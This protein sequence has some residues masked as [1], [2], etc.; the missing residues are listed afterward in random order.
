MRKNAEAAES[1]P[2]ATAPE[3]A[4]AVSEEAKSLDFAESALRV[5]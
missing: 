1:G 2:A 3:A 4:A 5:L